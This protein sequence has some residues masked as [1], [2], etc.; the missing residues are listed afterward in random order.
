M[1]LS[2]TVLWVFSTFPVAIVG[3]MLIP[4]S[5][6]LGREILKLKKRTELIVAL[7]VAATSYLINLS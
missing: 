3:A 7:L 5:M 1:L 6:E 2:T 4:A